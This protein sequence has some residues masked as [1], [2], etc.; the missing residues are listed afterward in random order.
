MLAKYLEV[1]AKLTLDGKEIFE[2]REKR[3]I[4]ASFAAYDN[5]VAAL[6]VASID[7]LLE[8]V[9][10]GGVCESMEDAAHLEHVQ[11]EV[12]LLEGMLRKSTRQRK[13]CCKHEVKLARQRLQSFEEAFAD[14]PDDEVAYE[15][16]MHDLFLELVQGDWTR[17]LTGEKLQELIRALPSERQ[18]EIIDSVDT[19]KGVD[20]MRVLSKHQETEFAPDTFAMFFRKQGTELSILSRTAAKVILAKGRLNDLEMAEIDP[21]KMGAVARAFQKAVDHLSQVADAPAVREGL[22]LHRVSP[23]GASV[24]QSAAK[25]RLRAFYLFGGAT[26]S[27]RSCHEDVLG[28]DA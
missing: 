28:W 7:I 6:A 18:R 25:R 16:Y 19:H 14:N 9:Q 3:R 10:R 2:I 5:A 11:R 8:S 24:Q 12:K 15:H 23:R 1:T 4:E 17:T 26:D 22:E 21:K 13:E 20:L 27:K